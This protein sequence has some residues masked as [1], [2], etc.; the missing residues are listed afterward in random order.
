M[1][2]S[3]PSIAFMANEGPTYFTTLHKGHGKPDH[4]RKRSGREQSR[5]RSNSDRPGPCALP[6]TGFSSQFDAPQLDL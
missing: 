6:P 1:M 5:D 4:Q 3:N 2:R